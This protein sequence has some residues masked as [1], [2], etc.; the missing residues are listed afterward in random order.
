LLNSFED[1]KLRGPDVGCKGEATILFRVVSRLEDGSEIRRHHQ[2]DP[3]YRGYL[4]NLYLRQSCYSC[5][6]CSI[7]RFSDI[8]LGDFWGVPKDLRDRRGVSVV[9]ANS[10]KVTKNRERRFIRLNLGDYSEVFLL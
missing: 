6:F 8:T 10:K 9:I 3:F 2:L 7:P 1:Q 4:F 5:P